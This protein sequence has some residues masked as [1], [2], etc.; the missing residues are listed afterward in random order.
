MQMNV[1]DRKL[2]RR[3]RRCAGALLLAGVAWG[4]VAC[5]GGLYI[6]VGDDDEPPSV[7]LVANASGA[8]AGQTVRLAA[9]ASDDFG[10]EHVSFYRVDSSGTVLLGTDGT[11]SYEWDAVMPSTSATSV[12]FHARAVDGGG[13][14]TQSDPV[15]VTVLR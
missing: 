2:P 15:T 14:V 4:L 11:G 13:Q 7:S 3:A 6:G 8:V 9:A 1:N 12:Q 5:G 10:I